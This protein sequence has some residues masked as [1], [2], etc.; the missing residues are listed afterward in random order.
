MRRR[1]IVV[2]GGGGVRI[3][4]ENGGRGFVDG[5]LDGGESRGRKRR[6]RR[7]RRRRR[8]SLSVALRTMA[9]PAAPD[10]DDDEDDDYDDDGDADDDD[11]S[12]GFVVHLGDP[13]SIE[14]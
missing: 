9:A 4:G 2:R 11:P 10:D 3:D 1:W 5:V 8:R 13:R 14:K 7:R 12:K 6:K